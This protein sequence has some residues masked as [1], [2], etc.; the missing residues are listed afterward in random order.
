MNTYNI[1]LEDDILKVG[2]AKPANGDQIV[3]DAAVRLDEMIA[4]GEFSGGKLLKIDG[5]ASLAVCY[6]IAH[7]IAHL[8]SAIAIFDPKIGRPGYKTFITAVSHTPAYKIGEIIETDEPQK[9]KIKV[10]VIIC[11]PPQSGKSCLREG[12][13]QAITKIENA[14]YPY[15]ITACPDGEGA[16]FSE[17]ARRD[18]ELARRLKDEYKA[19]F[20]PEFATKAAGWVRSANTPLNIIDIGGR[21]SDEN[22]A[23]MREATHAVILSGKEEEIAEWKE[24]CESLGLR[25]VAIIRSD[26]EA[27]EDLIESEFPVLTGRVHGL[28][29]GEDVSQREI[30]KVLA[31]VLVN[32]VRG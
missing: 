2:F 7:K 3:R 24:F 1:Q 21:R 5:P 26:I 29:R 11:G 6:L 14:P 25:I 22:R 16:W 31:Q 9:D 23:I 27:Q 20:T 17:A 8:Y 30:V 13:K 15:V 19:K 28:V 10:K 32:Q 12:L 18:L 4:S